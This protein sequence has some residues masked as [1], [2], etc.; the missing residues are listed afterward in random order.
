VM[1]WVTLAI[2]STATLGVV[3]IFDSHLIS[4]RMPSFRVY[5]LLV[6][7]VMLT[8]GLVLF[9]LFPLPP[10]ISPRILLVAIGQGFGR[11]LGVILM[12]Y[13]F[14]TEEV[15]RAVPVV[16]AYPIFVALMSAPLL[17]ESLSLLE[18]L[19]VFIVVAGAVI[20]SIRRSLS[21]AIA[22]GKPFLL[23]VGSALLFAVTDVASK[24]VLSQLSF[25]SLFWLS[26]FCMAVVSFTISVRPDT[27]RQLGEMRR[28]RP[29]IGLLIFAESISVVGI[30]L[31]L[32][33]IQ[34]GPV[35]LV[36]TINASRPIFVVF[37]ALVLSRT[38]PMFLEFAPGKGLLALRLVASA[39]IVS[40]IAII[41]LT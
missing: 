4:K 24:Y 40:G 10:D 17:G 20:V 21:G 30:I 25:L 15:S 11:I 31:S 38:S 3:N 22:L 16:Y 5:L 35:A 14:R 36:S 34:L 18:W 39:M 37:F 41:Y 8:Y 28:K 23:L 26:A 29:A 9:F 1:D 6:G 33:A 2:L 12:L 7:A 13:V 32:W 27:F 19:A